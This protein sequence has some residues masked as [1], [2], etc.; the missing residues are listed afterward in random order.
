MDTWAECLPNICCSY[1]PRDRFHANKTG[2]LWK[3][4]P[5]QTLHFA[6]PEGLLLPGN[7]LRMLQYLHEDQ[8]IKAIDLKDATFMLAKAWDNVSPD[9]IQNCWRKAGFPGV[10]VEPT[11]DPFESDKESVEEGGESSLWRRVDQQYPSL[12]DVS[13]SQFASLDED[14][15]RENQMTENDVERE[16]L[17]AVQPVMHASSQGDESDSDDDI[18]VI[19][20]TPLGL[21]PVQATEAVKAIRDFIIMLDDLGERERE[22]L[23]SLSAMEDL[24]SRLQIKQMRQTKLDEYFN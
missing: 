1:G 8:P 12:A 7:D 16:A 2:L 5:T 15:T 3:A 21:T 13:F 24:F 18:S 19:E 11:Q 22:F 6:E 4:T 17:E 20:P 9:T 23:C 10:V 14:V